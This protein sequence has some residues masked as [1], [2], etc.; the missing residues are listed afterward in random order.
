MY[1]YFLSHLVGSAQAVGHYPIMQPVRT[2]TQV[3]AY[4]KIQ[5]NNM[6]LFWQTRLDWGKTNPASKDPG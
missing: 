3:L 5:T 1:V 6:L 4:R 2:D